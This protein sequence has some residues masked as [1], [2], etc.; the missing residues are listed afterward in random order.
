MSSGPA[1]HVRAAP[2]PK[3][4]FPFEEALHEPP[5]V[6]SLMALERAAS[7]MGTGDALEPHCGWEGHV[8]PTCASWSAILACATLSDHAFVCE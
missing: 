4:S 2:T 1:S 3:V 8:Q 6:Q 5:L 7:G